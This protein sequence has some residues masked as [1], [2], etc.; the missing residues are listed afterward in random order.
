[1]T[2]QK[3]SIF[4]PPPLSKILF[5]PF[6]SSIANRGTEYTY[7][8]KKKKKKKKQFGENVINLEAISSNQKSLHG[9]LKGGIT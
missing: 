1:M 2:S 3:F 5:A 9:L 6:V 4:K 8:D 7:F